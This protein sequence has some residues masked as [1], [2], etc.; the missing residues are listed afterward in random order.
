MKKLHLLFL[1]IGIS[2]QNEDD[3]DIIINIPKKE[4]TVE[5]TGGIV[6]IILQS[7]M[8]PSIDIEKKEWLHSV[9]TRSEQFNIKSF[10]CDP[11]PLSQERTSKIIFTIPG[12]EIIQTILITQKGICK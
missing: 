2:C 9:N 12:S 5:S 4:Y 8:E 3:P 11:N 1:F 7:S 6:D 10:I